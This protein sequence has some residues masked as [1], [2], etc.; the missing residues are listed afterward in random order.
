MRIALL[1]PS[2]LPLMRGM[3]G[4]FAEVFDEP[5]SYLA[6]QPDDEYLRS[7]LARDTFFALVAVE[8][9]R[10]IGALA[11]YELTKF[12][13]PRSEMYIYD[14]GVAEAFRRRGVAT[15]LIGELKSI[16]RQRGAWVIFV[17]ADRGD[18]PAI[19]LYR[20][21]GSVEQVLHFDI[22]PDPTG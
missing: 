14:L 3:L 19:A 1:G 4:L 20:K 7:L 16:A 8:D 11:A 22:R 18:E 12:E 10:V 5:G 17:Q 6:A 2:D 21:L 13:Q 15:A 9:G